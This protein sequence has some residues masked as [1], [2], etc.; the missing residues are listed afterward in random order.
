M[1]PCKRCFMALIAAGVRRIVTRKEFL[2]QDSKAGQE[3]GGKGDEHQCL[4]V[5][6]GK[7]SLKFEGYSDCRP[8]A[9][10]CRKGTSAS[11]GI[12]T[13]RVEVHCSTMCSSA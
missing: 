2:T 11:Q 7:L 6:H 4:K 9:R 12:S 1:P 8:S 13:R 10:H 5:L 3:I